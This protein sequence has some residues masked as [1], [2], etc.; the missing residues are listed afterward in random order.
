[1]VNEEME[2]KAD[3]YRKY[4]YNPI[5]KKTKTKKA[6]QEKVKQEKV[7]I[8]N[9]EIVFGKTISNAIQEWRNFRR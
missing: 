5:D 2:A 1:M 7:K 6:K 9:I 8:G 3:S 4:E